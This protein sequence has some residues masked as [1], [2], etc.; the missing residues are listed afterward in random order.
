MWIDT[1]VRLSE[2]KKRPRRTLKVGDRK[3]VYR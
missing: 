3:D 1:L 2:E